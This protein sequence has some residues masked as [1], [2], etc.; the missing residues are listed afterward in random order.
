MSSN[1]YVY[2]DQYKG[3]PLQVSWEAIGAAD[4]LVGSLGGKVIALVIGKGV[5]G[6]RSEER[7]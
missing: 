2:I 6:I 5:A 4:E 1:I 3:E 7:R